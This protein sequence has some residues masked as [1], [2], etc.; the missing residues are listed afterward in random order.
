MTSKGGLTLDIEDEDDESQANEQKDSEIDK[1]QEHDDGI[2]I[3]G[4]EATGDISY[5]WVEALKN[6]QIVEK[7]IPFS[8]FYH[9]YSLRA[10]PQEFKLLRKLTESKAH[11]EQ[12]VKREKGKDRYRD[13][14][15]FKHTQVK[16]MSGA[17]NFDP[18]VDRYINANYI[19]SAKLRNLFIATQGPLESTI[20]NFWK[21]IWQEKVSLIV[22]LCPLKE[23]DKVKCTQ[24]WPTGQLENNEMLIGDQFKITYESTMEFDPKIINNDEVATLSNT[25]KFNPSSSNK[26]CITVL[27]IHNIEK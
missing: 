3:E 6:I 13:L 20:L 18:T 11:V 8:Q 14:G 12:I 19:R 22:M 26:P 27:T 7:G 17:R 10:I 9:N 1:L 21:M 24:Y 4:I 2:Q 25:T 16:L 23:G 15:P 5:K